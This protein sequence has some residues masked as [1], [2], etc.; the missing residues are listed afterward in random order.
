MRTSVLAGV[1][2]IWT[3]TAGPAADEPAKEWERLQGTW[4]L[5]EKAGKSDYPWGY[6][7]KNGWVVIAKEKATLVIRE[8]GREMKLAEFT[9][10]IDPSKSPKSVVLTLEYLAP[11]GAKVEAKGAKFAGVYSTRSRTPLTRRPHLPK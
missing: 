11:E 1:A 2:L 10:K 6:I 8:G 4:K 9:A 7:N 5:V 3:P